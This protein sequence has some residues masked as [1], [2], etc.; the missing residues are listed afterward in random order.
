M[1]DLGG[2]FN[3]KRLLEMAVVNVT[4]LLYAGIRARQGEQDSA[5]KDKLGTLR[6]GETGILL[7]G[8]K[9]GSDKCVRHVYLRQHGMKAETIDENRELMFSAGRSNEDG[10]VDA[11][12]R[13]WSGKIRCEEDIP[14]K[15]LTT[16][17]I[18]VTGRPDIILCDDNYSPVHG[19]ELKNISSVWTARQI[20]QGRPRV[21]A[22]MQAAHYSMALNFLPFSVCYTSRM[23]WHPGK[24]ARYWPEHIPEG[25][26]TGSDGTWLFKVGPFNREWKLRWVWPGGS[27]GDAILMINDRPSVITDRGIRSYYETL[28]KLDDEGATFP[29]D[30]IHFDPYSGE[31]DK[32][33]WT[34]DKYCKLKDTGL[35]CKDAGCEMNPQKW[36]EEVKSHLGDRD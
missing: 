13:S 7:P 30:T 14:T 15:W 29:V 36:L 21:K 27:S 20:L 6:G 25:V 19:I 5:E 18:P 24:G 9:V 35:C 12:K 28:S 10:W 4:D 31:V 8:G 23:D 3:L 2:R 11:L 32:E 34:P 26:Y 16:N 22:I 1:I 33:T 17:G